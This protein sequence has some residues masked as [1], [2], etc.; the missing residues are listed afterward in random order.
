[1]IKQLIQ[2]ANKDFF[3]RVAAVA[4]P[5]TLQWL[6]SS[7]RNLIDTIMIGKLG[8]L[9]VAAVGAAGKPFFVL[10]IVLYGL[11]G[12]TGILVAQYWGKKDKDRVS[13]N[14]LLSVAISLLFSI[15]I[16]LLVKI[17][18]AEIIGFASTDPG[19]IALGREYLSIIAL[20]IILQSVSMS[21]YVGL[22]TTNQ[23][24]KCTVISFIGVSL[25]IILNYILIFGHFGFPAMGLKGAAYATLISCAVETIIIFIIFFFKNSAFTTKLSSFKNLFNKEDVFKLLKLSMPIAI[26]GLTWAGGVYIYFIIYGRM[27]SEEL[28]IMTMLGPVDSFSVAFFGGLSTGAGILLGHSLGRKDYKRAWYESWVFLIMDFIIGLV[29]FVAFYYMR[30]LYL[31]LYSSMDSE[32]LNTARDTYKVFLFLLLFKAVNVPVI[33]GALRSGGDTKF[34]LF[35]DMG[36]QWLVGIPLGLLGAFVWKLPLMWVFALILSEEF[37]KMFICIHRMKSKKW[38]RNLI[39]D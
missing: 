24:S 6:L 34:V 25:N 19:V 30:D 8:V 26:N 2:T 18:S 5:A 27:G 23:A 14:I 11:T 37:V 29:I 4:I 28:A 32:T 7:S 3:T 35:L 36:C 20:N 31:G 22:R 39:S 33:I 38:L 15:P 21:L 12:G 17:F 9:Q 1:M 13:R 10:L 16:F